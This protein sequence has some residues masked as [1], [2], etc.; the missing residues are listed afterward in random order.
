MGIACVDI[1]INNNIWPVKQWDKKSDINEMYQ[2]YVEKNKQTS[3]KEKSIRR[4]LRKIQFR[5]QW[6]LVKGDAY[7]EVVKTRDAK[8]PMRATF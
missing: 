4:W 6:K 1:R 2:W 7:V 3:T 8:K 5:A